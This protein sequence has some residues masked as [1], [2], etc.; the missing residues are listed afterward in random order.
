MHINECVNKPSCYDWRRTVPRS[1]TWSDDS[2]KSV[3]GSGRVIVFQSPNLIVG[4]AVTSLSYLVSDSN[5]IHK[6]LSTLL[7]LRTSDWTVSENQTR[8]SESK[9]SNAHRSHTPCKK[10]YIRGI[11]TGNTKMATTSGC[12]ITLLVLSIFE[13]DWFINSWTAALKNKGQSAWRFYAVRPNISSRMS[14]QQCMK[15]QSNI[16]QYGKMLL[17]RLHFYWPHADGKVEHCLQR[18]QDD[19]LAEPLIE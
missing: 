10:L 13:R 6:L 11:K 2:G 15:I 7:A 12:L 4:V 8:S 17:V 1:S 19:Y 9:P 14:L 16:L 3:T 5:N 18:M